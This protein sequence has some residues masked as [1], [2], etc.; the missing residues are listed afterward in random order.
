MRRRLFIHHAGLALWAGA[1]D[2]AGK[3]MSSLDSDFDVPLGPAELA[4]PMPLN[5]LRLL[6][7]GAA[8]RLVGLSAAA[9]GSHPLVVADV[10]GTRVGPAQPL[11]ALDSLFGIPGWDVSAPGGG[12][13]GAVWSRPGSAISPLMFGSAQRA[14]ELSAHH[15]MGVFADPRAVRGPGGA[16][17][18]AVAD[19]DSGRHLVLFRAAGQAGIELPAAGP[20][21]LQRG[22]LLRHATGHLLWALMLPPGPRADERQDLRGESLPGG[23]LHVLPLDAG[24]APAGAAIQP[25]GDSWLYEF[26]ADLA[27]GQVQVFATTA[28]G[29]RVARAAVGAKAADW[30]RSAERRAQ[31]VL[32][33]PSVLAQGAAMLVAA[34]EALPGQPPRIL[35]GRG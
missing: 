21:Q 17:I 2:L 30:Q 11:F 25:F 22:L 14:A 33:S 9:G 7:Q 8:V 32:S 28:Q 18:T 1:G 5:S 3:T 29:H 27:D 15:P 16:G 13:I 31:G 24:L 6:A 12:A 35:L 34:L 19:L 23:V 26:D 10:A 4:Q 20:G